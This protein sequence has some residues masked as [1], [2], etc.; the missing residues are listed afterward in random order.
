VSRSLVVNLLVGALVLIAGATVIG[1]IVLWPRG[2]PIPLP[3]GSVAGTTY[4]AEITAVRTARCTVPGQRDCVRVSAELKSGPDEGKTTQFSSSA[5]EARFSVGDDVRLFKSP[6]PQQTGPLAPRVDPYAFSDFERR[7]PLFWLAVAFVVLVLFAARWRGFRALLGLAASLALVIFFVVPAILDGRS[8]LSVA[9]VGAFAVML[10]TIPLAH[11][12]GPKTIAA[13]LGTAGSLILTIV[14]A[15]L[16]VRLAHLSGLASEEARFVQ[17][18][19]GGVS[20]S[21]LLVAGMV[22]GALGVLDDL[23]VTQASTVL[24]LR[25]AN[26]SLG[27]SRLFRSAL[28]VGHD[29]ITATVNTLVLAYAGAA[30][31]VLLVFHLASV[32][33]GDAVNLEIVSGEIV[34]MLVGSI[35]LIAAVPTTTAI[36]ALLASRLDM[37]SFATAHEHA[38]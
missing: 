10:A 20:L 5:N 1:L 37:R 36:A 18:T 17:A 33:L 12:I 32:P 25:R 22:I 2:E 16:F 23:T 13:C 27:F 31:P 35:G 28:D 8:P 19:T 14:L 24:A 34:G 9:L 4:R 6:Q 7:Q 29:H 21:G 11:G 38:H 15:D 26:P 30:L 3:E